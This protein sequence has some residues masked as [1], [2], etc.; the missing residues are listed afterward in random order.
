MLFRSADRTTKPID[1]KKKKVDEEE[2]R[3]HSE[4]NVNVSGH[5]KF[6]GSQF[7]SIPVRG[8]M[9]HVTP[10]SHSDK[11]ETAGMAR[12]MAKEKLGR[13][14]VAEENIDE[15]ALLAL[16]GALAAGAAAYGA[17]KAGK[18]LPDIYKSIK[19]GAEGVSSKIDSVI[20][21]PAEELERAQKAIK[22]K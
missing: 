8:H 14:R 1:E 15:A 2:P 11:A 6:Q 21:P 17:Y 10:H 16:P 13:N 4:M 7:A 18:S 19:K 12:K 3:L 5:G 20:N 22:A 9:G